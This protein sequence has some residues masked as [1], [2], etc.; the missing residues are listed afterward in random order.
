[1]KIIDVLKLSY[2]RF[3]RLDSVPKGLVSVAP[4]ILVLS[5]GMLSLSSMYRQ[6]RFTSKEVQGTRDIEFLI[7]LRT[8]LKE[9]RGL[10]Q[11]PSELSA[12]NIQLHYFNEGAADQ[13]HY[14]LHHVSSG[15]LPALADSSIKNFSDINREEVAQMLSSRQWLEIKRRYG[16]HLGD[17]KVDLVRPPSDPH[18]FNRG[19]DFQRYTDRLDELNEYFHLVADRSN[20]ILDPRLDTYYLMAL[21][22]ATLPSLIDIIA[23][24]RG[25]RVAIDLR[26][27]K[28]PTEYTTLNS[29]NLE[30]ASVLM[31]YQLDEL[32]RV[33]NIIS[34]SAPLAYKSLGINRLELVDKIDKLTPVLLDRSVDTPQSLISHWNQSTQLI[35]FLEDIQSKGITILRK[36][37][38]ARKWAIA[39]QMVIISFLLISG[40]LLIY[41]I[42]SR[43]FGRLST[44]L[45]DIKQLANRDALTKLLSRR[46][47]RQLFDQAMARLS[48]S[49]SGGLGLCIL[50]IDFF[51]Q[52]NDMYGHAEGDDALV[53]VS[54][55]LRDSMLRDTDYAFRFGGEE[56]LLLFDVSSEKKMNYFLQ[57]IRSRLQNLQ[58]KHGASQVADCLTASLGGVFV[59]PEFSSL[60]LDLILLQAD[61]EL[62]KVKNSSRNAVSVVSL[63]DSKVVDLKKKVAVGKDRRC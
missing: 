25:R 10:R 18:N 48:V 49:S 47:L 37:L 11:F 21:S 7:H 14:E 61:C 60:G 15:D 1:M 34:F 12:D 8:T 26:A 44:A 20:L 3:P 55:L 46:S 56:F 54:S 4:I 28:N 31:E 62:Y 13:T 38:E 52:Y 6:Y 30:K 50:D 36:K 33:I 59:S 19:E 32:N 63:T 53:S 9:A 58:I 41:I 57:S 35:N 2:I 45:V 24:A 22:S 51:K 40:C 39:V 23:E 16:F 43:L 29:S 42:N 27:G 5:A 17:V